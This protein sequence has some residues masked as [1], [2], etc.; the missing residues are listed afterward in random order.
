MIS[1]EPARLLGIAFWAL[2]LIPALSLAISYFEWRLLLPLA[3]LLLVK[4]LLPPLLAA[5]LIN[6]A[7]PLAVD[8]RKA[9]LFAIPA[10]ILHYC[11]YSLPL[12]WMALMSLV[13]PGDTPGM[14][15]PT[16]LTHTFTLP[17]E[18]AFLA[19]VACAAWIGARLRMLMLNRRPTTH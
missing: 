17:L 7:I 11:L 5:L 19:L 15:A 10:A 6:L 3:L 13:Y 2:A 16:I 9:I 18:A 14:F 1:K 12:L 4:G 8:R